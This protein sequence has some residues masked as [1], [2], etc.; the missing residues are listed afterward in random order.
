MNFNE[1]LGWHRWIRSSTLGKKA[2]VDAANM[3]AQPLWPI[4]SGR[5]DVDASHRMIESVQ[6]HFDCIIPQ[7]HVP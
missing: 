4:T 1:L 7:W 5:F 2:G 3:E 6:M